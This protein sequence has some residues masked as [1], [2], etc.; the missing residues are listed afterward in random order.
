[1]LLLISA[2]AAMDYY[3][4]IGLRRFKNAF[5]IALER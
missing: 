5:G 3:P 4:K 2:P 1:M